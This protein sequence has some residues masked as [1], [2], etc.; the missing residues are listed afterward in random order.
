MSCD[1]EK[2]F[3]SGVLTD[4][5][6]G[7]VLPPKDLWGGKKGGLVV[8]EC[9]QRIPCNPCNTSCPTGAIKAFADINDR[10]EI[11]YAKCTGCGLCVAVCPGLACFVIDLTFSADK[12]L[13]K[14]PYELLPVPEKGDSVEC[15]DRTGEVVAKGA[16]EAVTE[17]K[18]DSTIVLHVSAPKSLVNDIRAIR[19]PCDEKENNVIV[20]RCE[21]ITLGEIR[22]WI[23]RGY[24]TV[25]EIKRALRVG[26]G[27]CQGR[28]CSDIVI[29]EISRRAGIPLDEVE[30]GTVRPPVKPVKI[31][32]LATGGE[33]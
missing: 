14:L 24:D 30:P 33:E 19:V 27:P 10:P 18:K 21:E 32:L 3:N 26:M 22:E 20:C 6:P 15:L 8:V 23:D 1:K 16:V 2:L 12:A 9:P 28:G 29:R 11:D 17:P 31:G 25:N 7:A 4:E 5:R 13:F